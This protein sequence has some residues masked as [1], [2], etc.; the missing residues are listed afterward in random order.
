MTAP[1]R[2]VILA[3]GSGQRMGGN[4]PFHPYGKS[5]LIETVIA[6][7]KPQLQEVVINAGEPGSALV[8]PLS[9]LGVR[10][11]Y[12][13]PQLTALGPLSGVLSALR[14]AKDSGDDAIITAPCDMPEVP[15]DMVAQLSERDGDIVHFAGAR[16]YP[17][18][19]LWRV[20]VLPALEEALQA[21]DR[22]LPVMRFLSRQQVTRIVVTDE[23][24][25]VNINQP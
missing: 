21:A 12:D 9:C 22:G 13:D 17:L 19:A 11:I 3:G 16:D 7:L 5:T 2:G 14:F 15:K 1:K 6:R 23:T 24:S 4:K 18:C 10:L 25:F 8:L 20:A